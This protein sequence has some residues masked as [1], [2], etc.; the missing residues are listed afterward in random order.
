VREGSRGAGA[1]GGSG[2]GAGPGADGNKRLVRRF[3]RGG[4][5]RSFINYIGFSRSRRRNSAG[6]GSSRSRSRRRSEIKCCF[7]AVV[8]DVCLDGEDKGIV[9][10]EQFPLLFCGW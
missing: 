2:S 1:G 10:L 4:W 5:S 8:E 9:C 6:R 3:W 7:D